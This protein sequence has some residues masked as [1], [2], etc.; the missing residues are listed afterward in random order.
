LPITWPVTAADRTSVGRTEALTPMV[1]NVA[2][3]PYRCRI[4]RIA[5]V[6]TPGP[7]SKVRATVFPLPGALCRTPYGADGQV[8]VPTVAASVRAGTSSGS[9]ARISS[10][11]H[12]PSGSSIRGADLPPDR[13]C[14]P[15]PFG[16]GSE[17]VGTPPA[18]PDVAIR[19]SASTYG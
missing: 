4:D 1:R 11:G 19:R 14:C 8:V 3:T 16:P 15:A 6:L 2:G 18:R 17:P 5:G 13:H 7:S 10:G 9:R 12:G